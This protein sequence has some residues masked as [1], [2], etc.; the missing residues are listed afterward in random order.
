MKVFVKLQKDV[1]VYATKYICLNYKTYLSIMET[2][3]ILKIKMKTQ[4]PKKKRA[5]DNKIIKVDFP[6]KC[7]CT[8]LCICLN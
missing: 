3:S 4:D 5:D 8:F 6:Q 1:F 7:H 2:I